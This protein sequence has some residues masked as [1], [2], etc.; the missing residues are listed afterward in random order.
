MSKYIQDLCLI[1]L[2]THT[3]LFSFNH[4]PVKMEQNFLTIVHL[5][6]AMRKLQAKARILVCRLFLTPQSNCLHR[7]TRIAEWRWHAYVCVSCCIKY[8]CRIVVCI[9]SKKRMY[10]IDTKTRTHPNAC[11]PELATRLRCKE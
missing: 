3:N 6:S 2:I 7:L 10:C 4:R 9:D 1:I 5:K 8:R 11:K